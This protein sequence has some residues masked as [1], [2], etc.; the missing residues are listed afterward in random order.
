M[1]ANLKEGAVRLTTNIAEERDALDGLSSKLEANNVLHFMYRN[2]DMR[3][4]VLPVLSSEFSEMFKEK[5][6]EFP[7]QWSD[8]RILDFMTN[9]ISANIDEIIELAGED[10]TDGDDPSTK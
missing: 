9:Y 3:E 5:R 4:L 1:E 2:S 6:G 7:E 10:Y 8:T